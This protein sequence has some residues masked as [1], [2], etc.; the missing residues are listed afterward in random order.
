MA[1]FGAE[2]LKLVSVKLQAKRAMLLEILVPSE[3][4][5]VGR[6][7]TTV[8]RYQVFIYK[9]CTGCANSLPTSQRTQPV[10]NLK[11]E[12]FEVVQGKN[13]CAL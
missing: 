5:A 1:A 7:K 13:H 2:I 3:N 10:S 11:N 9:N 8:N 4:F 12:S 6:R